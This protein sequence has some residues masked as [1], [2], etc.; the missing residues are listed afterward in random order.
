ML[1][2]GC[3]YSELLLMQSFADAEI[4]R[5]L[6]PDEK[7]HFLLEMFRIRRFEQTALKYY[8]MGG[9]MGGFL[10]LNIGQ[11]S[12]AVGTI[13]LQGERDDII[14]A[15]RDYEHARAGAIVVDGCLAASVRKDCGSAKG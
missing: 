4:N 15:H 2:A 3:W 11:E 6:T 14:T 13:S 1:F 12:V 8:Q 7:K 10:H 5:K 9:R